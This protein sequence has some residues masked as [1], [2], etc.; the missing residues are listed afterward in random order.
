MFFW[1][2]IHDSLYT[3]FTSIFDFGKSVSLKIKYSKYYI[4]MF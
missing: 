3:I 1:K 2:Y 4:E